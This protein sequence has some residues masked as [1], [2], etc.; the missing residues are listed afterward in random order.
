MCRCNLLPFLTKKFHKFRSQIA[1]AWELCPCLSGQSMHSLRVVTLHI[2]KVHSYTSSLP[3]HSD[4]RGLFS[5]Q[6]IL[7]IIGIARWINKY[8]GGECWISGMY[9]AFR[10]AICYKLSTSGYLRM[11]KC[12]QKCGIIKTNNATKQR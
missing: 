10:P 12:P 8:G 9:K 3:K 5:K 1:E 2:S 11:R 6:L 4:K 7:Q